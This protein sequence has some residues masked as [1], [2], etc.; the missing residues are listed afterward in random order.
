MNK[1]FVVMFAEDTHHLIIISIFSTSTL[2][3]HLDKSVTLDV[4]LLISATLFNEVPPLEGV[5]TGKQCAIEKL[6]LSLAVAAFRKTLQ[7]KAPS[8]HNMMKPKGSDCSYS[9]L[10]FGMLALADTLLKEVLPSP[11][12]PGKC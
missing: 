12:L 1:P 11:Q 4:N 8:T 7:R 2:V 6:S 5:G 3:L 9:C 10:L